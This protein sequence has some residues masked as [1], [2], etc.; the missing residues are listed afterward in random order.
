MDALGDALT[1]ASLQVGVD[2][3]MNVP[4][5]VNLG[6]LTLNGLEMTS[7]DCSYH[8]MVC[9]VKM[10]GSC[11]LMACLATS[12]GDLLVDLFRLTV[13]LVT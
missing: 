11:H 2:A 12:L 1:D 7:V 9:L 10:V 3:L 4:L 13:G 6:D 5:V 8:L